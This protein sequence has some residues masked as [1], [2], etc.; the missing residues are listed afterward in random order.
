AN[1][2]LADFSKLMRS[3]LENSELDFITLEKEID[4]LGLYLKLEHERFKDKFDFKLDIDPAIKEAHLQVPPML[5]Q[6]I[7][8]NAVWHG[9]RY[10]KEKGFLNVA[11]AKAENGI[12]V[13]ITDNGIGREQ[14]KAIKTDHQKKRDSKGLGNIKN[15]VALLNELHDCKI[16]IEVS[17]AGLSPDVGTTVIVSIKN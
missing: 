3:V 15:R 14:S 1:K 2:Y 12:K 13:T 5:L 4:L 17:D 8:E 16:D 7:I 10:K 6:P 9:L 11:F